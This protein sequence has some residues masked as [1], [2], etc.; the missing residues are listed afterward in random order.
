M[1]SKCDGKFDFLVNGE[2]FVSIEWMERKILPAKCY[3]SRQN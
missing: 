3:V 2:R 1:G